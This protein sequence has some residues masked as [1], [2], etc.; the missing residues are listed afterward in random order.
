MHGN[1]STIHDSH[2]D[3]GK[4]SVSVKVCNKYVMKF[5]NLPS[6]ASYTQMK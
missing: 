4:V 1:N 2:Y 5:E 6:I 3:E